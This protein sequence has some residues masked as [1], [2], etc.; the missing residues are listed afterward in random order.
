MHSVTQS[1]T[2]RSGQS[3]T[4]P[5]STAL[6]RCIWTSFSTVRA[7]QS[8]SPTDSSRD[9]KTVHKELL[10]SFDEQGTVD[11]AARLVS[12]YFDA[13]FHTNQNVGAAI[14][15]FDTPGV[16]RGRRLALIA[17][18]RYLAAHAPTQRE[19]E[20]TFFITTCPHCGERLHETG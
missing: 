3:S 9:P 11:H 17:G 10:A 20:Q 1:P 2:R 4:E 19:T 7:R 15:R 12:E 8:R 5:A 14:R 13:G 16:P 6:S 18:A